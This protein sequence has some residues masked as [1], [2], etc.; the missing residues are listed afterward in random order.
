MKTITFDY[1][2]TI[3]RFCTEAVCREWVEA[4][5]QDLCERYNCIVN[6]KTCTITG[7]EEDLQ[8][9]LLKINQ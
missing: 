2:K 5:F 3:E 9:I 1:D 6:F 4:G 7:E 8:K